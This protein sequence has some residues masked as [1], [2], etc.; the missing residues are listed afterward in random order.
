MLTVQAVEVG[1]WSEEKTLGRI[2]SHRKHW[3]FGAYTLF[4]LLFSQWS[5]GLVSC[6]SLFVLRVNSSTEKQT[7]HKQT[8][9]RE[10][11]V[12][13]GYNKLVW[14]Y[15]KQTK[16]I[17]YDLDLAECNWL[18]QS[19]GIEITCQPPLCSHTDFS[20]QISVAS[21]GS[22]WRRLLATVIWAHQHPL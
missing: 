19:N 12:E 15:K 22:C 16:K 8:K 11:S 20:A 3:T 7:I 5:T 13:R 18:T 17:N 9:Q 2:M 4:R 10:V 1:S 14:S 6:I 21:T